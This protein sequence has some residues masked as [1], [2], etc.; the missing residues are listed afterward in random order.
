MSV[1]GN[2]L[3]ITA[4]DVA[5]EFDPNLIRRIVE[6]LQGVDRYNYSSLKDVEIVG[7]PDAAGRS[8]HLILRSPDG[9]RWQVNVDNAGVLSTT[10]ITFSPG[11]RGVVPDL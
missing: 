3:S 5:E 7:E 10:M 8:P 9:N 6:F 4:T 1:Q 2:P 11:T